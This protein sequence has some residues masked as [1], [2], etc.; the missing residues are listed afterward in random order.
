M[1]VLRSVIQRNAWPSGTT[2]IYYIVYIYTWRYRSSSHWC[3]D[4]TVIFIYQLECLFH[5]FRRGQICYNFEKCM[6]TIQN[7]HF[8]SFITFEGKCWTKKYFELRIAIRTLD[9]LSFYQN[10]TNKVFALRMLKMKGRIFVHRS[11]PDPLSL[12]MWICV[13]F[14][15]DVLSR[16]L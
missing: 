10:C 5:Y 15:T 11:I 9:V 8:I 1:L 4:T 14:L 3:T 7:F 12:T 16:K 2:E 6:D 13:L